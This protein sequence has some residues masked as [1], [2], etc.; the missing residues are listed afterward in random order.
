MPKKSSDQTQNDLEKLRQNLKELGESVNRQLKASAGG[1]Y[2]EAAQLSSNILRLVAQANL[3]LES[4]SRD[5]Q[6]QEKERLQ[7]RALQEVGA[8]INSSLDQS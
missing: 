8:A 3:T 4:L 6:T 5:L 7:L 1:K 2:V